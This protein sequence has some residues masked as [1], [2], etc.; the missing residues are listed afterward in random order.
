MP[1][2]RFIEG[3]R[4]ALLDWFAREGKSYPWR[5]TTDPW[6]IIVSEIMLQ[7]TTIPTVLA[8]YGAWMKQFPTPFEL[9][10]AS[11]ETALRSWE[12]LGYYRR[13]RS[14]RQIARAVVERHGGEFPSDPEALMALPGIGEYTCGALL[15]FA[16][17]ISA[18]I[19]DTN[20]SRVIARIDNYRESVDSTPGK[21][22]MWARAAE[23]VDPVHPRE[24]NSAI[25]ELG[26]TF[27]KSKVADCLLCPVRGFCSAADP[28][29]LPVKMEKA[30]TS[31]LVHDDIFHVENG[32]LLLAR[33]PE[34]RHEGMYRLPER[35]RDEVE[36]MPL[37]FKQ[38]YSITRYKVT[39]YVYHAAGKVEK[40][41]NEV[42]VPFEKV[43]A[44]PMASP[45]RKALNSP[46]LLK[47]IRG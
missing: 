34:G 20:V 29:S 16:F 28:L 26:Q 27:C 1:G 43:A 38:S 3:F 21:K 44:L 25:M 12:G 37:L 31:K 32:C 46:S 45:D 15:S 41:E 39:R 8:R 11:E 42:L 30:K 10:E 47:L 17:N 24:F 36:G 35:S 14:L 4:K 33:Q 13:V 19:V 40:R 5:E 9:A 22:Y 6:H 23:L 7:Q 2:D 18:P